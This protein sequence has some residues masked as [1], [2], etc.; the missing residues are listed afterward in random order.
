M[1]KV[2]VKIVYAIVI[3]LATIGALFLSRKVYKKVRMVKMRIKTKK[4]TENLGI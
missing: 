3:I 4:E 2:L 1:K